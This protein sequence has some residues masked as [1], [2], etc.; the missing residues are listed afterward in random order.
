MRACV[1]VAL[2]AAGVLW[3]LSVPAAGWCWVCDMAANFVVLSIVF[4]AVAAVLLAG[5]GHRVWRRVVVGVLVVQ[6]FAVGWWLQGGR[7][8]RADSAPGAGSSV[9]VVQCNAK[10][11]GATPESVFALLR[12]S[13]A[14]LIAL[15]EVS[16]DTLDR[17]RH[18]PEMLLR[19]PYRDV[20]PWRLTNTRLILSRWPIEPLVVRPDLP[21]GDPRRAIRLVRVL[22]GDGPFVVLVLHPRS[23]RTPSRWREGN[24]L[25]E[26]AIETVREVASGEPLVVL[27]D[28]NSTPTGGRSRRLREALGVDRCKPLLALEGTYP[29]WLPWPLRVALD[30]AW[31]SSEWRVASWGTVSVPG[32]DHR[33]VE[34]GLRR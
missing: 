4:P 19:Y 28:L 30:D 13:G 15:T 34:V 2:A 3:A 22:H 14:D 24:E 6:A 26:V 10:T 5:R 18:D 27:A 33:A 20:P 8:A 1:A 12:E 7:A 23:P 17:L 29:A 21:P 32:S 9:R 31:V 25:L 16:G 11:G